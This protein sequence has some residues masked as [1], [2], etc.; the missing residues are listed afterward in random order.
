MS[1]SFEFRQI[2]FYF[3]A[4]VLLPDRA[5]LLQSS[6]IRTDFP[7]SGLRTV[8]VVHFAVAESQVIVSSNYPRSGLVSCVS[9]LAKHASKRLIRAQVG[10]IGR[11][12]V[13]DE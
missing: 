13:I 5:F 7:A 8:A 9:C 10:L 4:L 11:W 12:T 1:A 6:G 2:N 3:L